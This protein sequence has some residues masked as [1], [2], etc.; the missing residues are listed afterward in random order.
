M[1]GKSATGSNE[2]TKKKE[3]YK[4]TS[5][6]QPQ[7]ERKFQKYEPKKRLPSSIL[8]K[9]EPTKPRRNQA[10]EVVVDEANAT[11]TSPPPARGASTGNANSSMSP[12][13]RSRANN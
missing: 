4:E 10:P 3:N 8:P 1:V 11:S 12:N 5:W 2:E 13:S 6:A 9:K 7:E